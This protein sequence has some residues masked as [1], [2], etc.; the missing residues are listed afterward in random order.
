L[1]EANRACSAELTAHGTAGLGRNAK[2]GMGTS[3]TRGF[4][5]EFDCLDEIAILVSNNIFSAWVPETECRTLREL[6]V[7]NFSWSVVRRGSESVVISVKFLA[8]WV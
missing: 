6:I 7:P 8:N 3:F 2:G 5:T 1:F 4:V